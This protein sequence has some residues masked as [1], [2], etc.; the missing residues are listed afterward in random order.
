MSWMLL[1]ALEAFAGP[2]EPPP[3]SP[4]FG[5]ALRGV[6]ETWDDAAIGATYRTGGFQT[7]AALILPLPVE[8]FSVNVEA[9]Y[10]RA[11]A[12]NFGSA[13]F[14]LLPITILGEYALHRDQRGELYAGLGPAFMVFTEKHPDNTPTVVRGTR[15]G[16]EMRLGGRFDTGLVRPPMAPAPQGIRRLELEI[17]GARRFQRPGMEGFQLGAWRAGLGVVFRV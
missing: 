15:L 5:L 9:T 14:E 12:A 17:Y 11:A 2:P 1:A 13:H 3:E 10:R 8:P 6:A 16:L 4:D 7:G